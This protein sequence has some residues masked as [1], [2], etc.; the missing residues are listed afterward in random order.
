M[1]QP[2]KGIRSMGTKTAKK[3][4]P[5]TGAPVPELMPQIMPLV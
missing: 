1:K 5:T 3:D 4:E 2:K